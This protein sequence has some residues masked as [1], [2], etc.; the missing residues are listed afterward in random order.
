MCFKFLAN[1]LS[2]ERLGATM[3]VDKQLLCPDIF[4]ESASFYCGFLRNNLLKNKSANYDYD[5]YDANF[6]DLNVTDFCI[7]TSDC[8]TSLP[9][10]CEVNC[11]NQESKCSRWTQ[12]IYF[13][14]HIKFFMKLLKK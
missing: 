6:D 5:E 13:F 2:W 7:T 8:F 10:L 9:Y 1:F 14:E 4:I 12:G 11:T 3:E